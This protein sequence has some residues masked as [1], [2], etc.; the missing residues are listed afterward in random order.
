MPAVIV[1]KIPV[2]PIEVTEVA[3]RIAEL[4][5]AGPS[6]HVPD[7]EGPEQRGFEEFATEWFTA[8]GNPKRIWRMSLPGATM[9]AFQGGESLGE[10]PGY[11][12]GTFIGF[13]AEDAARLAAETAKGGRPGDRSDPDR[14]RDPRR[15]RA[16]RRPWNQFW[17][18]SFFADFP[19]VDLPR[20]TASTTPATT[21][22]RRSASVSC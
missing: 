16:C 17:P 2:Q 11:G 14:P 19:T 12:Q 4:V 1:P 22:E 21:A 18:E 5:D 10:L 15:D 7:I 3:A 8:H 9:R 6:G 20:R 13:A